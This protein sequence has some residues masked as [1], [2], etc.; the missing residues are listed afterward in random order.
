[1]DLTR[2]VGCSTIRFR[3]EAAY[4]QSLVRLRINPERAN[5]DFIRLFLTSRQGRKA[6]VAVSSG[7]VISN[8]RPEALREIEI[9]L[10][11]METQQ[12]IVQEMLEVEAQI[13][14]FEDYL[15]QVKDIHDTLREGLASGMVELK[16][17]D[18]R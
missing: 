3:E 2:R 16:Q 6:L 13:A 9:P 14:E 7:S 18:S 11:P 1:M 12:Q 5:P 10:P 8:L 4:S 17:E 15:D